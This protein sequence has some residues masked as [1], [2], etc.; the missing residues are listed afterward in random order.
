MSKMIARFTWMIA[1]LFAVT[2]WAVTP[3]IAGLATSPF[4]FTSPTLGAKFVLIHAGT[5]T[6]GSPSS[7]SGRKD[8][9]RSHKVTMS[10]PFFMQTTE[11]TQG[12]WKKVMGNNPSKFSSCGDD[13]PVERVSWD[14]VQ[15]FI[16]KLN[17]MERKDAYGKYRLP[18]EAEWEYAVR[19]GTTT[20]FYSGN[21]D[22][23]LSRAGWYK[24]N[25][26]LK[27]HPVGQRT[28][29]DWGLYDM[30]GNVWEWVQDLW[31]NYPSTPVTDPT[32][33]SSGVPRVFRGGSWNSD[34]S[35]CRAAVRRNT[36]SLFSAYDLGFRLVRTR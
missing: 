6:M 26:G 32:G 2:L 33:P 1:V 25:S 3:A 18:T 16:S 29:N 35:Y 7:E 30:H 34:A 13:C 23:N 4:T 24:S 31:S 8:D 14:D 5:F 10:Q 20:R 12:Q 11:V 9:E 21:N 22:N 27:T 28:P 19:A 36:I 15:K 17:T